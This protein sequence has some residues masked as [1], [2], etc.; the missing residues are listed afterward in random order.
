M[1]N[2][3]ISKCLIQLR[4]TACKILKRNS[5]HFP[6]NKA[7]IESPTLADMSKLF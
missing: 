5:I 3:M 7:F 1:G 6:Q 2:N 4:K